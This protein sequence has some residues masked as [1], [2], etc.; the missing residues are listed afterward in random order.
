MSKNSDGHMNSEVDFHDQV[1]TRRAKLDELRAE[2]NPYPNNFKPNDFAVD[3]LN[4]V[5]NDDK[6]TLEAKKITV[7]VCGRISNRRIMGKASFIHI[8]DFTG[9]IQAYI[10]KSDLPEGVYSKFKNWDLGDIVYIKGTLFRTQTNE[11]TIS[12]TEI[13]LVTKSLR[14]MPDKYHGLAEKEL[15]YRQRYLDLISNPK[16]TDTFIKRSQIITVIRDC[17][18]KARFLEVETPM[19][20]SIVGG[21]TARPFV[22][23]HNALDIPLYMRIAPELFLKRLLVG[24]LDRVFEINRN[25]RNEGLSTRHNP[26][27]T[28]LEFYQAYADYIDFMDFVEEMLRDVVKIVVGKFDLPFQGNNINFAEPFRRLTIV[29][30][31]LEY[32][33]NISAE[34]I[35]DLAQARKIAESV[36][37]TCEEQMGLG[38]IQLEI[39]EKT[40][41]KKLINPTFITS[42]PTETSPLARMNNNDKTIVDRCELFIGGQEVANIFS[43]L[44]DPDDQAMRFKAQ[45][46]AKDAGDVEA[47]DYDGD[48]IEALEYGMPPAAGAGIGID[49]LVMILTDAKAIKDVILFPLLRPLK[50][51][52]T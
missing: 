29:E 14:P 2:G 16:T 6:P 11:I 18:I 45:V 13:N 19:M 3:I 40:V 17:L 31:I 32:N 28:M 8:H 50:L 43:E 9:K 37:I 21:A 22:T 51:D 23:H 52:N 20:H 48:Y 15:C 30:S 39:F 27:F 26:E 36:G 42:Y 10:R 25:F 5:A 41:E 24:G 1:A 4:K 33:D 46:A 35:Q 38:A 49:R 7:T 44:N 34:S 47:M 12:A